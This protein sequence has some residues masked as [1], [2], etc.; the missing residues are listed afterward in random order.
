MQ[1]YRI[2]IIGYGGFGKFL[3]N[4]WSKLD[5]VEIVAIADSKV[6]VGEVAGCNVYRHWEDLVAAGNI[7][8]VSI[9]TPPS[10][11]AEIACAALYAGKH[12]LVEKPVAISLHQA[13]NILKAQQETGKVVM[14]NHMLRYNPIVEALATISSQMIFG[15]LRHATVSNYA[16]DNS[17]PIDHWF[18][19]RD[20]S[21]GIFVEHGVH[22]IDII[23]SLTHSKFKDVKGVWHD[24]NDRQRDQVAAL[25]HYEDGL[26][27]HHYHAFSGP[28]FF[29]Q[30]TIR[31]T[32]DLAKIEVEGWIPM[33]G[34]VKG[35]VN[36]ETKMKLDALP[37]YKQVACSSINGQADESRP[38]GWGDTGNIGE[39]GI[40]FGGISYQVDEIIEG[41]FQIE[42]TKDDIYGSCVQKLLLDMINVIEDKNHKPKVS[43]KDAI[44]SLRIALLASE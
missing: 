44:E 11:H 43:L 22:F 8:I 18:W 28:G 17:L 32:F 20:F 29:E 6:D 42:S 38:A 40:E 5:N 1:K 16:Q 13:E 34:T 4:W 7:D 35:L 27:A 31:L 19:N 39:K 37:G 14:V 26:I 12:V 36:S 30:T 41:N 21:G 9:V 15:K 3:H 24:R 2:G 25:V 23:S 10:V 33:L